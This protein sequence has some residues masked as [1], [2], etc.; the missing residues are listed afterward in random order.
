MVMCNKNNYKTYVASIIP[1]VR[2]KKDIT[3]EKL[4]L[5]PITSKMI[6]VLEGYL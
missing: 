1:L 5:P 2:H 6:K 4:E 3:N